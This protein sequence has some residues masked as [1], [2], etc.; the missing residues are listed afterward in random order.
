MG[1][2]TRKRATVIDWRIL[3]LVNH[4]SLVNLVS[5]NIASKNIS[6]SGLQSLSPLKHLT[7]LTATFCTGITDKGAESLREAI[8]SLKQIEI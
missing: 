3:T 1:V 6:D 5:L 4:K 8:P 7:T 2:C